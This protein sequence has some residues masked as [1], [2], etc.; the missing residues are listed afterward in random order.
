[1][2]CQWG[3]KEKFHHRGAESTEKKRRVLSKFF[4]VSFGYS[5]ER[6]GKERG[7]KVRRWDGSGKA[8]VFGGFPKPPKT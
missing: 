1:V 7:K 5:C 6:C 3:Q 8:Y 2:G 4:S